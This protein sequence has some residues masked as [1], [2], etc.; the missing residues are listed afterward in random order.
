MALESIRKHPT[1]QDKQ[2]EDRLAHP[3]Y[4][5]KP[6]LKFARGKSSKYLI[7]CVTASKKEASLKQEVLHTA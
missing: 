1:R 3:C 4:P 7:M 5:I 6:V 2:A